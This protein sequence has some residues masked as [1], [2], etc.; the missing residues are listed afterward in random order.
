M[1]VAAGPAINFVLALVIYASIFATYGKVEIE[2][3]PTVGVVIEGGIAEK[4]GIQVDDKIVTI[5]GDK[6]QYFSDVQK[7]TMLSPSVETEITIERKGELKTFKFV[8]QS[9]YIKDET[10]EFVQVR[11]GIKNKPDQ[12]IK[13]DEIHYSIFGAITAAGSKI[14]DDCV[15]MLQ[16]LAQVIVGERSAKDMGGPVKIVEYSGMF[17]QSLSDSVVC[18][19]GG[20]VDLPK[21][22][23]LSCGEMAM[24]G[25]INAFMFMAMISTMLGLMNLLPVP[26][27][28]GGHLAF[29]GI[30][31]I[32]RRPVHEA[33][34]E[35]AFRAGFAFL[36]GL[37]LYVTYNDIISLVQRFI[38]S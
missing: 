14:Y 33:V 32:I 36:I 4:L 21:G 30:E 28:D 10:G 18:A 5:G 6:I 1:I 38:L 17:T 11:L 19:F 9:E 7:K 13:Q 27:L 31:A 20:K 2:H 23:K 3:S 29:Y 15:N 26:M 35:W 8:P 37:M 22:A 12:I 24:N 25:F 16:G 34:Q